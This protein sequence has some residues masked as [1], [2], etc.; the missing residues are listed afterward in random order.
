[1]SAGRENAERDS[2]PG[3]YT[4]VFGAKPAPPEEAKPPGAG[5]PAPVEVMRRALLKGLEA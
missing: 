2:E 3:E 5:K 4:S 1:M